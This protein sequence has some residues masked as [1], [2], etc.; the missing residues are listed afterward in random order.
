M[1]A[2]PRRHSI[3][4]GERAPRC[5]ALAATGLA[6][7]L[8]SACGYQPTAQARHGGQLVVAVDSEPVSLNPLTAGDVSSVRAYAPLYPLLY[9]A[10]PDLSIAPDLA[11]ALPQLSADGLTWTVPLRPHAQW[12]DGAPMTAADV[13]YTVTTESDPTLAGDAT[14]DWSMVARVAAVDATTVRFTLR[15]PDAGFGAR[16]VTP[17][18]P[19]HVLSKYKPAQMDTAFFDTSPAVSGGPFQFKQRE[20]ASGLLTYTPNPH[21]YGGAPNFDKLTVDVVTDS[22]LVPPLLAQG[23]VLWS[24]QLADDAVS[25]AQQQV[26]VR[27]ASY[28][29][30]SLVA[31]QCNDRAGTP[32][33]SALVRQALAAAL[34]RG[35]VAHA[36]MGD[37]ATPM[38]GDVPPQSWAYDASAVP[39][40]VR[41]VAG[42]RA[43]LAQA[44]VEAPLA[45]DLLYPRGD[46]ARQAAAAS[47]AAQAAPAGFQITPRAVDPVA[48]HS[49]LASGQF[50]LALTETGTSLDP[51]RSAS[52]SAAEVPPGN[53]AGLNWGGYASPAMDRLLAAERTAVAA[54]GAALQSARRPAISA[55]EKLLATDLPFIPLYAPLHRAAY[56]VTVNGLVAGAQLD[57]DRDSAMYGRW[58]LAA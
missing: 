25:D 14:F 49:A 45:L 41:D 1:L 18:V 9:S 24:P 10:R 20:T 32:T 38:W 12:S 57:Q 7:L 35:A 33:G 21:W 43:L 36:A 53:P 56:N 6:A 44:H 15:A 28:P 22:R 23:Q 5:S 55:M 50:S 19:A 4:H 16:L 13:V 3:G 52:L 8:L 37:N 46:A 42:A 29:E 34:D 48:L 27:L 54:P 47:I 51:D 31:L 58:Y 26:G 17:V 30:L 2:A 11:A 39:H 40:T